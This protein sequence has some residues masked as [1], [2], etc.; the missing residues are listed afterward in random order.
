[1]KRYLAAWAAGMILALL[2]ASA[3]M[4]AQAPRT[5]YTSET[6]SFEQALSQ[7]RDGDTINISAGAEVL[8]TSG[9]ELK[10]VVI[11][12]S[13]TIT[14]GELGIRKAGILLEADVTFRDMRLA[15]AN[16]HHDAIFAN[17]YT[18]TIDGVTCTSR[19]V[20]LFGGSL[21]TIGGTATNPVVEKYA[22]TSGTGS[23]IVVQGSNSG[24]GHIYAGSMN[25]ANDLPVTIDLKTTIK[26][27]EMSGSLV[28]GC[29]AMEGQYDAD[30]FLDPYAQPEDPVANARLYPSR[31]AVSVQL[32]EKLPG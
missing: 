26:S 20:D 8:T 22:T 23:R 19:W 24:F 16:N 7:A 4:A 6:L 28:Y 18:L 27:K 9:T 17:G 12:K 29:G 30:N 5:I 15:M 32:G 13:V 25:G 2:P 31:A 3:A 10:P 11:D 14:G 1:M 21:Y